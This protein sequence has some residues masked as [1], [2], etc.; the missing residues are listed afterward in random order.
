MAKESRDHASSEPGR[1]WPK[2]MPSSPKPAA[3]ATSFCSPTMSAAATRS[4]RELDRP[5]EG[6]R[7]PGRAHSIA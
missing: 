4:M 6:R 7:A 2:P 3:A 1:P 5:A